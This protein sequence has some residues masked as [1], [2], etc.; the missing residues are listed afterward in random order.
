MPAD[1]VTKI[2]SVAIVGQGGTGKTTV[3]DALLF[4][5]GAATRIGRVDDGTSSFDTEPEEARRKTSITGAIHHCGWK[6]H[7]VNLIDTPG[8]SAFLHDTRN[9]LAAA[10]GVVVVLGS[11]GGEVKVEIEK[12]W[13]WC[14]EIGLPRIGFVTRLDRERASLDHALADLATLGAK[15]AVLQVPIG[16]EGEFKGVVDVLSGRAFL[17]Q[18]DSGTFQEGA[19]PADLAD[20]VAKARE[21][22]VEAIA[23]ANDPLLEKYLEGNELTPDELKSG[24]HDAARAGRLLPILCGSGARAIGLHP[25]LDAMVDLL[26]SAAELPAWKG[27]NPKN[28]E[29]SRAR[30]RPER[31]VLGVLLQDDRRPVRREAVGPTRR[32][33]PHERRPELRERFAR[34]EGA[35]RAPAEAR[36]QE[37]D[38]GDVGPPWRHHRRREAQGHADGRHARRREASDRLPAPARRAR[39]H[40]VRAPAEEQGRRREG[41][42]GPAPHHGG[43]HGAPRAP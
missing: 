42:A 17:Y 19:A 37:A 38:A 22:L 28:G 30:R 35:H 34:D 5:A 21:L 41:H 13:A 10:T 1:D 36:G 33:G 11:T 14:E 43:G 29:E 27:D 2:R 26:P 23:E 12:V 9:C 3:A 7:E 4:A 25:L 15:P 39:G 31:A 6:K 16:A 32:L 8:Y 20:A 40:L 24:L 18:G